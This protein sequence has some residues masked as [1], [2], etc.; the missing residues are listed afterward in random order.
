[1]GSG[2]L[3]ESIVSEHNP[4]CH[5]PLPAETLQ[6]KKEAISKQAPQAQ[7]FALGQGSFKMEC[8]KMEVLWSDE[9]RFEVLYGTPGRHV[10][11][12]R[13]DKDNPSCYQRSVKKPA[14]LMPPTHVLPHGGHMCSFAVASRYVPSQGLSVFPQSGICQTV[15]QSQAEAAVHSTQPETYCSPRIAPCVVLNTQTRHLTRLMASTFSNST[16]NGCPTVAEKEEEKIAFLAQIV[17]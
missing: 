2:I 6:C 1:M 13:E 12:T 10:I 15:R 8:G 17:E 14:S 7:R 16:R 9:S 5:P 4:P 3:P 11:R